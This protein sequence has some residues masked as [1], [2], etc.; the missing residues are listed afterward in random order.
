M[1]LGEYNKALTGET[2]TNVAVR[3]AVSGENPSLSPVD[4]AKD[5]AQANKLIYGTTYA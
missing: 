3:T 1:S 5:T 4:I 2:S